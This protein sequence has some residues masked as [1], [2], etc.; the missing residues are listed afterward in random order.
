MAFGKPGYGSRSAIDGS[1]KA[2]DGF[3]C[4]SDGA[5]NAI[6]GFGRAIDGTGALSAW[7]FLPYARG[8]ELHRW[9]LALRR[10]VAL[11]E[12]ASPIDFAEP[13]SDRAGGGIGLSSAQASDQIH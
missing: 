6:D 9:G 5:R 1:L 4:E 8:S 13:Y 10:V 3:Q 11:T 2:I 7:G 12:T